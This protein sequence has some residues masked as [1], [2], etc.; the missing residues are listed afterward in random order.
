MRLEITLD[1][2]TDSIT[3]N[4]DDNL[5]FIDIQ[6]LGDTGVGLADTG[7]GNRIPLIAYLS[8]EYVKTLMIK[9]TGELKDMTVDLLTK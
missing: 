2:S 1:T 6:S 3:V 9:S 4:T 5:G 8:Q 7:Q